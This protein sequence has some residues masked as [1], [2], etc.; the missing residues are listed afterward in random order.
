MHEMRAA[1]PAIRWRHRRGAA[2]AAAL[3]GVVVLAGACMGGVRDAP[4][5]RFDSILVPDRPVPDTLQRIIAVRLQQQGVQTASVSIAEDGRQIRLD[6]PDTPRAREAVAGLSTVGVLELRR[7]IERLPTGTHA[8]TPPHERDATAEVVLFR[9]VKQR[10]DYFRLG[11]SSFPDDGVVSAKAVETEGRGWE[12]KIELS[13]AGLEAF[14]AFAAA[15][16]QQQGAIIVD[17]VIVA[18]ARMATTEFERELRL[19]GQL[20][21]PQAEALAGGLRE[22]PIR[23]RVEPAPRD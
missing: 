9:P 1:M 15:N 5:R 12:V 14:Q 23:F 21:E 17:G 6:L 3:L 11:P 4:E 22:G 13:D 18:L 8:V 7:V 10:G 20:I 2:V 16:L 19:V